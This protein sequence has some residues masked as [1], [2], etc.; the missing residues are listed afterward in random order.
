MYKMSTSSCHSQPHLAPPVEKQL[1]AGLGAGR[2]LQGILGGGGCT[3]TMN[4][5]SGC[6]VMESAWLRIKGE[7]VKEI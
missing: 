5:A 3:L 6:L 7:Q 2:P 1:V 4:A